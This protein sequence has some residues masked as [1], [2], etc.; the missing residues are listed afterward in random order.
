MGEVPNSAP[1][2]CR[3]ND[4]IRIIKNTNKMLTPDKQAGRDMSIILNYYIFKPKIGKMFQKK[5]EKQFWQCQKPK[6]DE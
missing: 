1:Y 4:G 3:K 5:I 6:N 2:Y